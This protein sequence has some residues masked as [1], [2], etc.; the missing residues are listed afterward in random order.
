MPTA[1]SPFGIYG[2]P[3]G[4][5][6]TPSANSYGIYGNPTTPT[7]PTNPLKGGVDT[8]SEESAFNN[9]ATP[10]VDNSVGTSIGRGIV[11][12]AGDFARGLYQTW[13]DTPANIASD[14][15][16]GVSD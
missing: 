12:T 1:P 2:S 15:S 8:P 5:P 13:R 9:A 6:P 16:S 14:V 11:N 3:G 4:A 10:V 7:T